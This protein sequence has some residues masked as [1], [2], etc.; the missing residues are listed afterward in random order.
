M[1]DE[2]ILVFE[3]TRI[4]IADSPWHFLAE[5]V[6]RSIFMFIFIFILKLISI[7]RNY[8]PAFYC[9]CF[10]KFGSPVIY[11]YARLNNLCYTS[12]RRGELWKQFMI[13]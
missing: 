7:Q 4:L 13:Y 3:I 6:I 5:V 9:Y 2:P 10:Y 1:A 12:N 8:E 11:L